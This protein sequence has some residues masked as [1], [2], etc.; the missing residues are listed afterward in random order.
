MGGILEGSTYNVKIGFPR[1]KKKR[2]EEKK[3][4]AKKADKEQK[5]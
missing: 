2:R 1:F 3:R 4:I 5:S